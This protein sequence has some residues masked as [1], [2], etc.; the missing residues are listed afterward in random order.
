MDMEANEQFLLDDLL[1]SPL[2]H[3]AEERLGP[4]GLE[5]TEIRKCSRSIVSRMYVEG[6][7]YTSLT[8]YDLV[9][10]MKK[11]FASC[12]D[13]LHVY[14]PGHCTGRII[15]RSALIY[16]RGKD[17]ED[18]ALEL[19]GRSFS[20]GQELVVEAYPFDATHH[21]HK[22]AHLRKTDNLWPSTIFVRGYDTSLAEDDVKSKL[23]KHFSQC[24]RVSIDIRKTDGALLWRTAF[25]NV[26]G[27]DTIEKVLLLCTCDVE[28]LENVKVAEVANPSKDEDNTGNMGPHFWTDADAAPVTVAARGPLDPSL[29]LPPDSAAMRPPPWHSCVDSETG[30]LRVWNTKTEIKYDLPPPSSTKLRRAPVDP[31]LPE[32]WVRL[33]D[34]G[35][36]YFWNTETGVT[37]YE[38]P[39][40]QL[41]H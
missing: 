36:G 29:P 15:N 11:H 13:V 21:D 6:Y 9:T 27:I 5:L 32:P 28:G 40:S 30:Y 31:T 25:L 7:D 17:A 4:K 33:V 26:Y 20:G 10:A 34:G 16:L 38:R 41:D 39:P 14:I 8:G 3:F 18:M 22:F 35:T 2:F 12:G 1:Q 19:N 37:Q 24:G 23:D